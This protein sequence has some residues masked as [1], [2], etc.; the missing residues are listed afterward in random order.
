MGHGDT[1]SR[2]GSVTLLWVHD[3]GSGFAL[4]AVSLTVLLPF[5]REVKQNQAS[6]YEI[7]HIASQTSLE[8]RAFYILQF[9][10][11]DLICDILLQQHKSG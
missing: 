1:A 11:S 7:P 4:F 8:L 2:N 3:R 5:Y 9:A 10:L 6:L